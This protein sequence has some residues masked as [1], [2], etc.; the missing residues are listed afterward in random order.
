MK[1]KKNKF[2]II[3]FTLYIDKKADADKKIYIIIFYLSI[4]QI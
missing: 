1:I 3:I 2:K 4:K